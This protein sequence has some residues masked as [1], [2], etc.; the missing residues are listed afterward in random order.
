MFNIKLFGKPIGFQIHEKS[1]FNTLKFLKGRFFVYGLIDDGQIVYV[2]SSV[3]IFDRIM[4]HKSDVYFAIL[5]PF[6]KYF[7]IEYKSKKEIR[8]SEKEFIFN[9]KPKYNVVHK[10]KILGKVK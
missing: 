2:G 9:I 7:L 8:F 10:Y 4:F 1:Q 5:K 6:Q 3:N